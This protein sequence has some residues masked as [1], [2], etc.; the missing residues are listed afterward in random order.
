MTRRIASRVKRSKLAPAVQSQLVD[1]P[2]GVRDP[3]AAPARAPESGISTAHPWAGQAGP[4]GRVL[5]PGAASSISICLNGPPR[6]PSAGGGLPRGA[7]AGPETRVCNGVCNCLGHTGAQ[8]GTTWHNRRPAE[9]PQAPT[10][11]TPGHDLAQR[12]TTWHD[13]PLRLRVL[14]GLPHRP[15]SSAEKR[16]FGRDLVFGVGQCAM[17]C[18]I[19]LVTTGHDLARPGTTDRSR[20][21]GRT[22]RP[23]RFRLYAGPGLQMAGCEGCEAGAPPA[24]LVAAYV[25]WCCRRAHGAGCCGL[26]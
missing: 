23:R 25:R 24:G 7:G 21:P 2:A 14:Q 20:C 16:W 19:A 26:A 4:G 13:S 11:G 9:S 22:S 18:A 12:G 3:Q 8:P 10:C 6:L 17:Q 1:G 5:R 15:Q